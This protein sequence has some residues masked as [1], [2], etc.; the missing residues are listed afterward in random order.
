MAIV[1]VI[2]FG[3]ASELIVAFE[4][5]ENAVVNFDIVELVVESLVIVVVNIVV[6]FV[7]EYLVIDSA[8]VNFA[9]DI[10]VRCTVMFV[11][12]LLV[13]VVEIVS[14]EFDMGFRCVDAQESLVDLVV[15]DCRNLV[16]VVGALAVAM[17]EHDIV[18]EVGSH[19]V[20]CWCMS[21]DSFQVVR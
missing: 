20:D 10:V 8:V 9:V 21:T 17:L 3:I 19:F 11:S 4:H 16:V 18:V 1:V 7:V 2:G 13:I 6:K 5:S 15:S 12:E 14:I